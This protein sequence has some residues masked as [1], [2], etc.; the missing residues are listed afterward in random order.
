MTGRGLQG[1]ARRLRERHRRVLE[2]DAQAGFSLVELIVAMSIFA[3]ILAIFGITIVNFSNATARTAATSDQ[4]TT[5]RTVYNLF[6]KQVRS[7]DAVN[8][9]GWAGTNYYV[10]YENTTASPTVCTQWVVRTATATLATRTWTTG[11]G[12][13]DTPGAWRT[14]A[15]NGSN[16]TTDSQPPFQFTAATTASPFQQ[17]TLNL[18]FKQGGNASATVLTSTFTAAN[19]S[20]SSKSNAADSTGASASPICWLIP[21]PQRP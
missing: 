6:D 20:T 9:P 8:R 13:A 15:T 5:A 11:T 14:V 10:E 18:R 17:L 7:A 1:A 16:A 4:A 19:S 12:S 2:G 3:V 21:A